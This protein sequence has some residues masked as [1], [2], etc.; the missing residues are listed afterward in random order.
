M[1]RSVARLVVWLLLVGAHLLFLP[2]YSPDLNPI[3]QVF[4][5]LEHFLRKTVARTGDAI[6]DAIAETLQRFPAH[7]CANVF[8]NS[9]YARAECHH[10]LG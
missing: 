9:G 7:E 5:K 1:A 6:C 3:E 10:A 4:A 8:V 2:K